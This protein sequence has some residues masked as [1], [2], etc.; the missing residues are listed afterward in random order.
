MRTHRGRATAGRQLRCVQACEDGWLT[1]GNAPRLQVCPVQVTSLN[2]SSS[3]SLICLFLAVPGLCR[4]A[5]AFCVSGFS[6]C[7]AQVLKHRLGDRGPPRLSY[8]Q[9]VGLSRTRDQ[10]R[11]LGIGGQTLYHWTTEA[12]LPPLNHKQTHWSSQFLQATSGSGSVISPA[13]SPREFT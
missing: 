4:C 9:P 12:A 5:W 6:C 11:V 8:L 3:L 10:T 7:R 13:V 1:V 2:S